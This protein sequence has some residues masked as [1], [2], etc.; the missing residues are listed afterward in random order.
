MTGA[1]LAAGD[2][3]TLHL[4]EG[5]GIAMATALLSILTALVAV[6]YKRVNSDVN[7]NR[8]DTRAQGED[9]SELKSLMQSMRGQLSE[10]LRWSRNEHRSIDAT[11]D[12]LIDGAPDDLRTAALRAA[13][14]PHTGR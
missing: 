14:R 5:I 8:M 4:V 1:V 2:S 3:E 7:A 10:H 11:F 12:V 13:R 9:I 6:I